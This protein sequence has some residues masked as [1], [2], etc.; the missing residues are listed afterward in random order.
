MPGQGLTRFALAALVGISCAAT[1]VS[2]AEMAPTPQTSNQGGV[3]IT[4]A[5]RNLSSAAQTW[6]FEITLETHTQPLDDDLTKS[7]TLLADGKSHPALGWE[8]A[9][10]GGHHRKG[11]LR[12][13]AITPRPGSVELRI[14]RRGEAA[15]RSF[16]WQLK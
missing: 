1:F 8:G 2:A 3:K 9:P 7:A 10:P 4:V 15:A 12:F 6:D 16:R 14:L 11:V 13:K 5:P